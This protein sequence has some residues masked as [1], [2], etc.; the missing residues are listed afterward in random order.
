M[1]VLYSKIS[2]SELKRKYVQALK[3]S[4]GDTKMA[5]RIVG[6]SPPT[7]YKY[8]HAFKLIKVRK[9]VKVNFDGRTQRISAW[10]KELG[11]PLR[12]LRSR[13]RDMSVKKAFTM[14]Y[15]RKAA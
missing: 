5:M 7:F 13:V 10:S 8:A 15:E 2:M 6:H 9:P 11:I 4:N 1:P 3:V 12:T 14:P